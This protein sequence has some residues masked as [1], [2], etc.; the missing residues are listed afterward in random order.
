ME[1]TGERK[2]LESK[3]ADYFGKDHC[4]LVG[5]GT[6][7]L[8]LI[9]QNAN[10]SGQIVYPAYT[11]PSS[12]YATSYTEVTPV[13]ADVHD[14]YTI[15]IDSLSDKISSDT[16]AVLAINL[17]G[18]PA[19]LD[20]I[21]TICQENNLLLIED[22]CQSIGTKYKGQITGTFGDVS[23]VSFGH[24]K[25]IDAGGGGAVLTDDLDMAQDIREA[26]NSMPRRTD[27]RISE[28]FD[29]Y[30]DIYYAIDDLR[31]STPEVHALYDPLPEAF[32]DLFQ[33]G[34]KSQWIKNI[35]AGL[36]SLDDI[37]TTRK[38]HAEIY[39]NKL[40][41]PQI[42][43]PDPLGDPVHFRYSIQLESK[44]IRDHLVSHLR[45]HNYH[46][47]TLYTPVPI[48]FG[49]KGEYSETKKLARQTVN[50]W[51]TPD[52]NSEYVRNC[53]SCILSGIKQYHQ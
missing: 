44:E 34:F 50:L 13:F 6:T 23:V 47:S 2:A 40:Q 26:E 11:C 52:V 31:E 12:V 20:K 8:S 38:E 41:H 17:F 33:Y 16:E 19:K 25:H 29:K 36:D 53:C 28:L 27:E 21:R 4:I 10:I 22:A 18:H 9:Y 49:D 3:L 46:I 37:C 5:R 51:V 35:S 30:R 39:Q 48:Q 7:G 42:T 15:S 24:K 1:Q 45:K 14:D 32:H 43:H